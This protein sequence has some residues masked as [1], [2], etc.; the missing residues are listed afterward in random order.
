M[1][2]DEI[3]GDGRGNESSI[4]EDDNLEFH[5]TAGDHEF[6]VLEGSG[7]VKNEPAQFESQ[8]EGK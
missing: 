8:A 5:D 3:L 2:S 7:A 1:T 4:M 6:E